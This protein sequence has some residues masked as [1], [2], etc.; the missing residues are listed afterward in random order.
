MHTNSHLFL[1]DFSSHYTSVD[2]NPTG[3]GKICVGKVGKSCGPHQRN[4]SYL[5]HT[6]HIWTTLT[7]L[8]KSGPKWLNVHAS[9]LLVLASFLEN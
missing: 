7:H 3:N 2:C 4:P 1:Y 9:L 8:V 6:V 5:V